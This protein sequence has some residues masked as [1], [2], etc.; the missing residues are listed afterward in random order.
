[1]PEQLSTSNSL[2]PTLFAPSPVQT[3]LESV[4]FNA[5][6]QAEAVQVRP[7]DLNENGERYAVVGGNASQLPEQAWKMVRTGVFKEWFGDWEHIPVEQFK[8]AQGSVYTYDETGRTA[9]FKTATDEQ[10][11]TQGV[12]VFG[13]MS[14]DEQQDF[15]AVL[16]GDETK[17]RP[18]GKK[19][20]VRLGEKLPDGRGKV[21]NARTEINDPEA[22]AIVILNGRNPDGTFT[23]ANVEQVKRT[24]LQPAVGLNTFDT[25]KFQDS[26][27]QWKRELHLGNRVTEIKYAASDASKTLEK[28]EPRL[29]DD[30]REPSAKCFI[31]A[32]NPYL[33]DRESFGPW[34]EQFGKDEGR[35]EAMVTA[36]HEAGYDGIFVDGKPLM[37]SVSGKL[38]FDDEQIMR[39]A[40]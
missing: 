20:S 25:R 9:R 23:K 14:L 5:E 32:A 17:P 6:Q 33:I 13:A 31:K 11:D 7:V 36:L 8:T 16:Y 27:G 21:V 34:A 15:L 10:H 37:D 38:L 40:V 30:P 22:L 35:R 1:M 18:D 26:D 12:T 39:I 2:D 3:S 29:Y 19:L 28:G 24:S 4:R